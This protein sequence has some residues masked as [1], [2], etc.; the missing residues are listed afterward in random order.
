MVGKSSSRAAFALAL[1]VLVTSSVAVGVR[2]RSAG[3]LE[4]SVRA[5]AHLVEISAGGS[6]SPVDDQASAGIGDAVRTARDKGLDL[7]EVA[8]NADPPVCR[9]PRNR[10]HQFRRRGRQ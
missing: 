2:A 1:A 10:R 9:R 3:P 6:S 7:V 8:P 4:A 5:L